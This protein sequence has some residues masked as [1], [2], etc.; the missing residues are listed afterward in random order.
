M[1]VRR[2]IFSLKSPY[3]VDRA[4]LLKRLHANWQIGPSVTW[5]LTPYL[6]SLQIRY[7]K[8]HWI[9]T[10]FA[11]NNTLSAF[12][13][14]TWYDNVLNNYTWLRSINTLSTF[15]VHL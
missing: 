12:H 10:L 2:S 14:D 8:N 5:K 3:V 1:H 13:A 9:S 11:C 6:H 15:P 4:L 7:I